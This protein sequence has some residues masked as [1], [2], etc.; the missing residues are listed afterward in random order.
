MPSPL[1]CC[2]AIAL[3]LTLIG[4]A[5]S[6]QV[7][8]GS[9]GTQ[10]T[11]DQVK[12]APD[13]YRGQSVVFGGEVLHA[14]RLKDGTRIEILQLPLDRSGRPGYDRTQSQGRFIA[15]HKEFLDPA[16]LPPGTGVTVTG[17]ITGTITLPLD[18]TEYTYPV[19]DA[20]R[21]EVMPPPETAAYRRPYPYMGP[22]GY[23]GPYGSPYGRPWP[24]R[25]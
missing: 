16:T 21:I 14:R 18:E 8:D 10:V 13:S 19:M 2:A 20:R 9:S 7:Q 12:A 6:P 15:M 17:E 11:F 3:C 23:W 24:Y 5:S 22:G 1:F 4:C 25:W